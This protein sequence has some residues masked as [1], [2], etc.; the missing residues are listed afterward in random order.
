MIVLDASALL[1][2]LLRREKA[3]RI[4]ALVLDPRATLHAPELLDL[5]I[6]QVLRRYALGGEL[7]PRRA[8]EALED[9]QALPIAR[10]PHQPLVSGIW[11]LRGNLTAYDAAYVVLAETLDLPLLTCDAKLAAIPG[12]RARILCP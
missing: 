6:L 2:L 1:E 10:Y 3:G 7:S 5:E 11:A 4:G 8:R 9:F 12:H